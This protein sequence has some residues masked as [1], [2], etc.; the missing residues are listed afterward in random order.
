ML[1]ISSFW[2]EFQSLLCLF[3]SSNITCFPKWL[4]LIFISLEI[5]LLVAWTI[6]FLTLGICL[7]F[8]KPL[9]GASYKII[10]SSESAFTHFSTI[11]FVSN[12]S[13]WGKINLLPCHRIDW[14][15]FLTCSYFTIYW[16]GGFGGPLFSDEESQS[17]C[18]QFHSQSSNGQF[19]SFHFWL[20]GLPWRS[21]NLPR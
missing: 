13:L 20:Y 15:H 19:F 21:P 7:F 9:Q 5:D 6:S 10:I 18:C 3:I 1:F 14:I 4:P 8:W 11:L 2:R 17:D 12:P 16:I